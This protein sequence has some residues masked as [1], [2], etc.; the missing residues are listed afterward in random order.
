LAGGIGHQGAACGILVG[1]S[2]GLTLA[3]AN[4]HEDHEAITARACLNVGEYVQR[5][6]GLAKGGF[7]S[8]IIRTDFDDD[9][10]LRRYILTKSLGCV[11]LA[12]RAAHILIDI[13]S[14]ADEMPG[15][16]FYDLNREFSERNFQCAHSVLMLAADKVD[17]NIS[18]PGHMLIPLNG[19]IGYSGS[20][21]A[22][23]LGGCMVIGMARG[24]DTSQVKM[25][26]TFR[27]MGLTLVYGSKAFNRLDLSPAN[28]ALLRCAELAG[29]FRETYG[30]FR[31]R[32][33]ADVDFGDDNLC[34]KFF[35]RNGISKC[36]AMAEATSMKAV[37][38]AQ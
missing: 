25:L 28:D 2:L 12:S 24:G 15:E 38:L 37:E 21:C 36:A 13:I 4:V 20:T 29:W 22:A 23:L 32:E 3:S 35:E 5:F 1:G 11:R 34:R 9:S 31:C 18:L 16:H 8:E 19:G 10:Q 7:C 26:S 33:I 17:A 14:R 6:N 30:S 27:R